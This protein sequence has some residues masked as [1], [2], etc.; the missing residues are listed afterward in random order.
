MKFAFL[1]NVPTSVG[2][3]K[4]KERAELM[5][6]ELTILSKRSLEIDINTVS[7]LV[8]EFSTFDLVHF[9]G[10]LGEFITKEVQFGLEARGIACPNNYNNR[11]IDSDSKVFQSL[12]F[13]KHNIPVPKTLRGVG[14][15]FSE[16]ELALK[17]PFVAKKP[18]STQGK[19]VYLIRNEEDWQELNPKKEFLFQEYIEYIADYRVHVV[20]GVT[21]CPYQRIPPANDFRANVSLGGSLKKIEDHL[22]QEKLSALAI[23]SAQALN[24]EYCGVDIIEA[25]SGDLFVLETNADPGYKDVEEVTGESFSKPIIDFYERKVVEMSS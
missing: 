5:G 24:L 8:D 9:A 19:G 1:T 10:G 17:L 14:E 7:R 20:G 4:L 15:K 12:E 25:K 6:H 2:R 13:V 18:N 16:I 11:S 3:V 22:L 21:F 23:R